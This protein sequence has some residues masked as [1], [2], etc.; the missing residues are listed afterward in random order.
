MLSEAKSATPSETYSD[1]MQPY[2]KK[3]WRRECIYISIV[4]I[5]G[6]VVVGVIVYFFAIKSVNEEKQEVAVAPQGQSGATA[7]PH[8][9]DHGSSTTAMTTSTETTTFVESITTTQKRTT[10]QAVPSRI[11]SVDTPLLRRGVPGQEVPLQTSSSPSVPTSTRGPDPVQIKADGSSSMLQRLVQTTSTAAP[12]TT[13]VEPAKSR[14]PMDMSLMRRGAP[15]PMPLAPDNGASIADP[16]NGASDTVPDNGASETAYTGSPGVPFGNDMRVAEPTPDK[17]AHT[18]QTTSTAAPTTTTVKPAKSRIPM[19]MSLMRRGVPPPMPLAPDNDA[20]IADPN[21]GASDTA[22]TGSPGV[23]FGNDMRVPE[24]SPDKQAH[25]VQTTSTA[26]PTTTTVKPAKSRIPMDMSLMRRGA[27][28]PMPLAPDNDASIAD[29]NNGASDTALFVPA[30]TP[31]GNAYTGS[32]GVPFGNDTR[33]PEPSPDKQAHTDEM[34]RLP[35]ESQQSDKILTEK[36]KF[37]LP[38]RP[39]VPDEIASDADAP[40]TTGVDENAEG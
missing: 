16:N 38:P 40:T 21:N 14:I 27:P 37:P 11:N 18:V 24:P 17:Q 35:D 39:I 23:P 5:L 3:S 20:S 7:S 29:P 36:W 15:P 19:D 13:T 25:T 10:I 33:V 22:Y 26:A 34:P 2:Q 9:P 30:T 6:A 8:L 32:P 31:N 28:P 1:D 4:I 12:T